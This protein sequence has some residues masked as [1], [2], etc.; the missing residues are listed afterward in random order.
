MGRPCFIARPRT[1]VEDYPDYNILL[2]E[3]INL[4]VAGR[5]TTASTLTSATYMLAENPHVLE[6]LR[7]EILTKIGPG[8]RPT[9][10]DFRDMKYLRAFINGKTSDLGLVNS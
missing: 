4:A 5:D 1:C 10:D 2:D 9:F 8:R 7:T 6:T 3:L